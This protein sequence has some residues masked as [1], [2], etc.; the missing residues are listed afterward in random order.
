MPLGAIAQAKG[1]SAPEHRRHGGGG[2]TGLRAHVERTDP[3]EIQMRPLQ[4]AYAWTEVVASG[5]NGAPGRETCRTA[6]Y[7]YRL[8]GAIAYDNAP[9]KASRLLASPELSAGEA[10]DTMPVSSSGKAAH[11]DNSVSGR[12]TG[13]LRGLLHQ[14]ACDRSGVVR[15][16]TPA[17]RNGSNTRFPGSFPPPAIAWIPRKMC[18]EECERCR[19]GRAKDAIQIRPLLRA[20]ADEEGRSQDNISS[21]FEYTSGANASASIPLRPEDLHQHKQQRCKKPLQHYA[22]L[23]RSTSGRISVPLVAS[24]LQSTARISGRRVGAE[25]G[26]AQAQ[27][28]AVRWTSPSGLPRGFASP[29]RK[30]A[31]LSGS[32]AAPKRRKER[33][34]DIRD[35]IPRPYH[36]KFSLP[37]LRSVGTLPF[38]DRRTSVPQ[39]RS[40]SLTALRCG[41][42]AKL[43]SL[44][45][46]ERR[47]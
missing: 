8:A 22:P 46:Q 26:L 6:G 23:A 14:L 11:V 19:R 29:R 10:L 32:R 24:H 37:I 38:V 20:Y 31:A 2:S 43:K 47:G 39:T 34:Q 35:I 25:A 17:P 41:I 27:K 13:N 36:D 15:V 1:S 7:P 18:L 3:K 42:P 30:K 40:R 12:S 9:V 4:S 44:G 28:C 16:R 21:R 5:G 45:V 33:V